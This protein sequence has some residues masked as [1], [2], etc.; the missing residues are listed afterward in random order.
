ML[1]QKA[2]QKLK[3]LPDQVSGAPSQLGF[4]AGAIS[5]GPG[6]AAPSCSG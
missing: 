4:Y 2:S 6:L 1:C 3:N 5:H